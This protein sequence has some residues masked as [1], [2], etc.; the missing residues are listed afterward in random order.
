MINT[1]YF[2]TTLFLSLIFL[3][4]WIFSLKRIYR[5]RTV[6]FSGLTICGFVQLALLFLF[7]NEAFS[8]HDYFSV[9]IITS[10]FIIVV[11]ILEHLF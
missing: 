9:I 3:F 5:Y 11:F 6:L 8:I 7:W 1:P 4:L 10:Y 2:F